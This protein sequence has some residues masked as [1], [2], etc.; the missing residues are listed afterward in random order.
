M[1]TILKELGVNYKDCE[2][3]INKIELLE[4]QNKNLSMEVQELNARISVQNIEIEEKKT[5]L[6]EK[7]EKIKYLPVLND[8][9]KAKD[10]LIEKIQLEI[11]QLKRNL[12]KNE[13][14]NEQIL[15][16]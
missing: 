10:E 1:R 16:V 6:E 3:L 7:N 9:I 11:K 13:K 4:L 12:K 5:E 2:P 14:E 15:N 8:E